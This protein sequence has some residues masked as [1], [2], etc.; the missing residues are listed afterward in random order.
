M[1]DDSDHAFNGNGAARAGACPSWQHGYSGLQWQLMD[2]LLVTPS[3]AGAHSALVMMALMALLQAPLQALAGAPHD[4]PCARGGCAS[5][6]GRACPAP[7]NQCPPL[8]GGGTSV[9]VTGA[10]TC[11]P[12]EPGCRQGRQCQVR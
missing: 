7:Y 3:N 9:G 8:G 10:Q 12:G 4:L 1:R 5:V 6:N 11:E 2:V